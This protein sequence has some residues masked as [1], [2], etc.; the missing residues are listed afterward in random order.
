[1]LIGSDVFST[2]WIGETGGFVGF[3]KNQRL[4]QETMN[5]DKSN[6]VFVQ[7][8]IRPDKKLEFTKNINKIFGSKINKIEYYDNF[9]NLLTHAITNNCIGCCARKY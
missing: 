7:V 9:Y 6:L 2:K 4:V 5:I 3:N 1:M 8:L